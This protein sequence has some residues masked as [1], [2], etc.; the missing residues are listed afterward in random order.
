MLLT[1]NNFVNCSKTI[2]QIVIVFNK[3]LKTVCNFQYMMFHDE[4]IIFLNSI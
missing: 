4:Q 1:I 3:Y 2:C